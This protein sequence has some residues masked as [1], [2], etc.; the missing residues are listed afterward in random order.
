LG[1]KTT[2]TN[3]KHFT[4]QKYSKKQ[5][6]PPS[7]NTRIKKKRIS[8]HAFVFNNK[9]ISYEKEKKRKCCDFP[10]FDRPR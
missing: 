10:N 4:Q 8:K 9:K 6:F 1:L 7:A 5:N 2:T 3:V